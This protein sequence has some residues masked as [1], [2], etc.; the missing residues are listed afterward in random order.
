MEV[1]IM[2]LTSLLRRF[3]LAAVVP[4][5]LMAAAAAETMTLPVYISPSRTETALRTEEISLQGQTLEDRLYEGL[6]RYET[7]I[8]ISDFNLHMSESNTVTQ[9]VFYLIQ[10]RT[11]LEHFNGGFQIVYDPHTE[12]ITDVRPGYFGVEQPPETDAPPTLSLRGR[13]PWQSQ[14]SQWRTTPIGANN[15]FPEIATASSKPRN[16]I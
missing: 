1:L 3:L 4:L 13:R 12:L 7:A 15:R 9:A 5:C 16:D 11:G 10:N 2:K 6:L 14:G 8:D